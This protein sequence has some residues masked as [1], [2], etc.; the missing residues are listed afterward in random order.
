MQRIMIDSVGPERLAILYYLLDTPRVSL[1]HGTVLWL[2]TQASDREGLRANASCGT[3]IKSSL[4][5]VVRAAHSCFG[6]A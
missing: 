6:H 1:L 4:P 3:L 2:G 5:R